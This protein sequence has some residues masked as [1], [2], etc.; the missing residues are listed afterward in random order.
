MSARLLGAALA[1]LLVGGGCLRT[2]Q[3]RA[4]QDLEVGF[5][6]AGGVTFEVEQGLAAIRRLEPGWIELWAQAPVLAVRVAADAAAVERWTV[7][8]SNAMPQSAITASGG[9][10]DVEAALPAVGA[11]V[12]RRRWTV[13]LERGAEARFVVAPPDAD[14]VEGWRF[15]I[16]NDLHNNAENVGQLRA[17]MQLVNSDPSI[18]FVL[19]AGDLV[20]APQPRPEFIRLQ[21]ELAQ[22]HV[23]FYATTGNHDI[24]LQDTTAWHDLFG[25][26]SLHFRFKGTHF[27]LVDS[28]TATVDPMVYDWLDEWLDEGREAV[29]VLVT[30]MPAI[31][32]VG[33]RNGSFRSRKE[34]AK[35]LAKL[36]A[37]KVDL[38]LH[39]HLHSYY[40][41]SEAGIPAHISAW[42][43]PIPEH[44][45]GIGS[46]FLTVDLLPCRVQRVAL[47]RGN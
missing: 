4:E 37:G 3:D 42:G 39:G 5:G 21:N 1:L 24:N 34:A 40:A 36:A 2:A 26:H 35:L 25:R 8:V 7:V 18:R 6:A 22:L 11:P 41:F 16:V 10:R 44:M 12:T 46:V 28:G 17:A 15:A 29:H 14:R 32:P 20:A 27:S 23:P 47:V 45:D 30:H 31:D 13:T 38:I 9:I 43:G 33:T 19:C